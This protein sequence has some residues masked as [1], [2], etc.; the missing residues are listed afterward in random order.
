MSQCAS[1][2][3]GRNGHKGSGQLRREFVDIVVGWLAVNFGELECF[4]GI[5]YV[6]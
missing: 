6:L 3:G 2:N 1:S 5:E 4:E